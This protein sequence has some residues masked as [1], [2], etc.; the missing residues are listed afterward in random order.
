VSRKFINLTYYKNMGIDQPKVEE[1]I[2][3]SKLEWGPE[4]GP[5][6]WDEARDYLAEL[7]VRL[8]GKEQWRMPSKEDLLNAFNKKVPGFLTKAPNEFSNGDDRSVL[9]WSSDE[10]TLSSA[11]GSFWFETGEF[12]S[13]TG[14]DGSDMQTRA[15]YCRGE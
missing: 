13:S 1:N 10:H 2:E 11:A 6:S 12:F 4:F 3:G 14:K 9:Y 5:C 15:R 8:T 7:N